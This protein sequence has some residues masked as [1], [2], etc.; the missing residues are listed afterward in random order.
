MANNKS[1]SRN[2]AQAG[3]R[4][5][6]PLGGIPLTGGGPA[7]HEM[8]AKLNEEEPETGESE[9]EVQ[10]APAEGAVEP[11]HE[12]EGSDSAEGDT[13][14]EGESEQ[15]PEKEPEVEPEVAKPVAAAAPVPELSPAAAANLTRLKHYLGVF[16]TF[17]NKCIALAKS[18]QE[19]SPADQQAMATAHA[20][21]ACLLVQNQ[22][23]V[24]FECYWDFQVKHINDIM[25]DTVA[26]VGI[27]RIPDANLAT[28]S[29]FI[30]GYFRFYVDKQP[31]NLDREALARQGHN[32][33]QLLGLLE[34]RARSYRKPVAQ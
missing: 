12:D 14:T 6:T 7:D 22:T 26:L 15:E 29:R 34:V 4:R 9:S 1:N 16:E 27:T 28:I 2:V 5:G 8:L 18:K 19:L 17:G 31:G 33:Y 11:S 10:P 32:V 24:M 3:Q 23:P 30:Y 25:V 20:N 13:S 21:A